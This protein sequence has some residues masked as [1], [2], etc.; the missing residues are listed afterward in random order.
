MLRTKVKASAI[1]NLTDARYFSAWEVDWLGFQLDPGSPHYIQP[2][3]MN[4]IREW[5]EGP[6]VVGEFG[7]QNAAEMAEAIELLRLDAI[8][9]GMFIPPQT[10]IELESPV[11]VIKE[12]V[13]GPDTRDT[14][15]EE[16]FSAFAPLVQVFL[17]DLSRAGID[18]RRFRESRFMLSPGA[19]RR[20]C[21]DYPVLLQIGLE[22]ALLDEI[23]DALP[24]YG[25]NLQ[26]GEEEQTGVKSFD[27][28]DR[29]FELLEC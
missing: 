23:L 18:W 26:G 1:T 16:F 22:P 27:E 25:F 24:L 5:V 12:V 4:A 7:L 17:V 6:K 11:P 28:L 21:S 3:V 8:Q 19:L 20:L 2:A 15:L 10:L 14:D 29:I 13:I 9:A